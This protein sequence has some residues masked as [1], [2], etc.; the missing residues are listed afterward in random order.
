[1]TTVDGQAIPNA[2]I[3]ISSNNNDLTQ[4]TDSQGK[5]SV[6]PQN[7]TTQITFRYDGSSN[8]NKAENT[9][10]LKANKTDTQL[11]A[12]YDEVDKEATVKL[13]D[14]SVSYCYKDKKNV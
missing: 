6:I 3:S 11:V 12:Q 4:T 9:I 8:Y 10:Q 1:M 5:V 13:T 14:Y 2:T 7:S